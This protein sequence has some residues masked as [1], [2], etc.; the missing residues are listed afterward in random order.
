MYVG[1]IAA[2]CTGLIRVMAI[3]VNHACCHG[4]G[5]TTT[6]I[7]LCFKGERHLGFASLQQQLD[8]PQRCTV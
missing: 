2:I 1:C 7:C 5:E 6:D 3:K 4:D 8:F